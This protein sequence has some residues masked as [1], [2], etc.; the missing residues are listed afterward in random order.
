[1]KNQTF[2]KFLRHSRVATVIGFFSLA[3]LLT[4]LM[5]SGCKKDAATDPV[6]ENL[7]S[8]YMVIVE[9]NAVKQAAMYDI[10]KAMSDDYQG[11]LLAKD[12]TYEQID[13][14]FAAIARAASYEEEFEKSMLEIEK[15]SA[16]SQLYKHYPALATTRGIGDAVRGF[17]SWASGS[18]ARSRNRIL[19]VA[20]NLNNADRTKLYNG[21]RS[22]WKENTSNEADFW[23]KLEK[24]EF[25]NAAPQMYN[26]F[27]NNAETDF[28]DLA[29][30]KGL[31][32]QKIVVKEGAEGIEK[33]AAVIIET[34]KLVSPGLGEGIDMVEKGIEYTEKAE[35][36]YKDPKG[37]L[38]D[39][40]KDK[41][42][43]KLGG[44][45]D[46]DGAI[47]ATGLGEGMG[48]AL[49]TILDAALGS[50]DPAD[51]VK[52]AIDW[53][54]AKL[55]DE[56]APGKKMD[57]VVAESKSNDPKQIPQ[58]VIGV[59]PDN[60]TEDSSIDLVL[61]GGEWEI[62]AIDPEGNLD[63]IITEIVNGVMSIILTNTNPDDKVSDT[64]YSLSAWVT[65]A[66]PG[67][68]E[69][70]YAYAQIYPKDAGIEIFFEI[71]GTD[72]YSNS[73][74]VLTD[75]EGRAS[76]RIPGGSSGTK[77]V[78]TVRLV[79]T[80]ATRTLSYVF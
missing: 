5:N 61:P 10:V 25:D 12:L 26:D 65:P 54:A 4:L 38:V 52:D 51:W 23:N 49:K 69:S 66:D 76:F 55:I 14:V 40:I 18:A 63:R 37:A 80:G 16:N 64:S 59:N 9:A 6:Q 46:V 34:T 47:D 29:V 2:I 41:I 75:S 43:D 50:D 35:K 48:K 73:E 42:A 79:K 70:V 32:I 58:V 22:N 67:P 77:D 68:G 39:E 3:F 30:D 15:A 60:N 11:E 8:H 44:F 21:L 71:V 28:Q 62:T 19:T 13:A 17:F 31:T 78:V 36:I 56:D 33:G 20:S 27:Y 24:G 57:I 74:T 7:R 72:G 1:M 45:V 53:G